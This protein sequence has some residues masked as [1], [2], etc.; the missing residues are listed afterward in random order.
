MP[1]A[2][3]DAD[4]ERRAGRSIPRHLRARRRG[5]RSAS[6]RRRRSRELLDGDDA[7]CSRSAAARCVGATRDA[8]ARAR[9]GG[10]AR[11]AGRRRLGARAAGQRPPAAG[12]RR[13]RV[14][15][16]ARRAPAASTRRP[17]TS[18]STARLRP[19][20]WPASSWSRRAA[21]PGALATLGDAVGDRRAAVIVDD[22]VARPGAAPTSRR[23][24]SPGGERG[25][26]DAG[27]S[28]ELWRDARGGRARAP[29]RRGRDRRRRRSP[30]SAGFAAATFRRGLAWIAV[31]TT[32]VGQVDAAIGGK[33]AIDVA[34]KNDVGAFHLPEVVIADP[35]VLETLPPRE[36]AAGFAEV[37]KT[38]LLRAAGCGSSSA[39][40]SRARGRSPSAHRAGA[41]DAPPTRRASSARTRPSRACARAQPGPHDRPR[42]R[43]GGRATA[44]CCTARRWRSGCSPRCACRCELARPATRRCWPRRSG[45]S[46]AP[47]CPT[48]AT[49][50]DRGRGARRRCAATRSG[51][52]VVPGWCCSMRSDRRCSASTLGT[53]R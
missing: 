42:R 14:P 6:S 8:R 10:L 46:S 32:L 33:T 35:V 25:E 34:A 30:T 47:G 5:R 23:S 37:V 21:A 39:A 19:R 45:S 50:L 2:D 28:S 38:A 29:R 52:A 15:R 31:P 40:G 16:A 53:T 24:S 22:A 18:R 13:G 27:S 26:V 51:P 41:P 17:A 3:A 43:G 4:I 12:P 44:S 7:A 9:D 48:R 20:S 49:G 36:W 1:F 11:R